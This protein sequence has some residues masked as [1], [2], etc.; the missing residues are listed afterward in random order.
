MED[1]LQ[2]NL[3]NKLNEEYL[4]F[5][6][7]NSD[8]I[9]KL[10]LIKCE[11]DSPCFRIF[12]LKRKPSN[13]RLK[14][15]VTCI[16]CIYFQMLKSPTSVVGLSKMFRLLHENNPNWNFQ[17]TVNFAMSSCLKMLSEEIENREQINYPKQCIKHNSNFTIFCIDCSMN[18]CQ[19]CFEEEHN[20]HN[21]YGIDEKIK[22]LNLEEKITK[23]ES[24]FNL[25]IKN[26]LT[27]FNI[28]N[29]Y[30]KDCLQDQK[31]NESTVQIPKKQI[32]DLIILNRKLYSKNELKNRVLAFLFRYVVKIY[33]GYKYSSIS[34]CV[35]GNLYNL[36]HFSLPEIDVSFLAKEP[37]SVDTFLNNVEI[38]KNIYYHSLCL[39][40]AENVNPINEKPLIYLPLRIDPYSMKINQ[41]LEFDGGHKTKIN[42]VLHFKTDEFIIA[43]DYPTIKYFRDD[44]QK[45]VPT[46]IMKFKSH[47]GPVNC[48]ARE[49]DEYFYSCSDDQKVIRWGK[50]STSC[51]SVFKL[52]RQFSPKYQVLE[53][54]KDKVTQVLKLEA[55]N[56]FC[57][58]SDD[59]TIRIYWTYRNEQDPIFVSSMQADDMT[60]NFISMVDVGNNILAT[61]SKDSK[62]RFWDYQ[63]VNY[64]S[65]KTI[66]NID[67][68]SLNSMQKMNNFLIFGG[69][70][71]ISVFNLITHQLEFISIDKS[72]EI[73]NE[74]SVLDNFNFLVA[75]SRGCIFEMYLM[76]KAIKKT[77][78]F[79]Y[80]QGNITGM[81][82]SSPLLLYVIDNNAHITSTPFNIEDDFLFL[83]APLFEYIK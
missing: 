65:E 8:I 42:Y 4:L 40:E 62:L 74:I 1:N 33:E 57:S 56:L 29:Q 21:N 76:G 54:H 49:S 6:K 66:E 44:H 20:F 52:I 77:L 46:L 30:L 81:I 13:P 38:I 2:H 72:L 73:V 3:Q 43:A 50:L 17:S 59:K 41:I 23:F 64:L 12:E 39:E 14:L 28:V 11:R 63:G 51:L 31:E 69:T 67:C 37:D 9:S 60:D 5:K 58:C 7:E 75:N 18:I 32:E 26:N 36:S 15:Q 34:H 47:K 24:I 10:N 71:K 61:I 48:L 82:R 35:I 22:E 79:N 70:S 55:P 19:K 80:D 83:Q 25:S 27:F 78:I 53:G 16:N 45:G 68:V